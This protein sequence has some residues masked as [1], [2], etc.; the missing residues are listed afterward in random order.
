MDAISSFIL[1]IRPP[2]DG[3]Q[4]ALEC[5]IAS[6]FVVDR[7]AHREDHEF[8]L[9]DD[10][11]LALMV[12]RT[13]ELPARSQKDARKTAHVGLGFIE[14]LV[15]GEAHIVQRDVFIDQFPQALA[16]DGAAMNEHRQ[17]LSGR[18]LGFERM[19]GL[20]DETPLG[21]VENGFVHVIVRHGS[22]FSRC[23]T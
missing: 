5:F 1:S 20:V 12:C 11:G 13:F 22:S 10:V 15:A 19:D 18:Q 4:N 7:R 6:R 8:V 14:H 23:A 9:H 21:H 3:L 17:R 16:F 2:R